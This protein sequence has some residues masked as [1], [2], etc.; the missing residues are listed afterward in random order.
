MIRW[1]AAAAVVVLGI[2]LWLTWPRALPAFTA[3]PRVAVDVG[4]PVLDTPT[5]RVDTT[6]VRPIAGKVAADP[7]AETGVIEGTI[8]DWST[9]RPVPE[10]EVTFAL[11]EA[12]SSV[13]AGGDGKF[14]FVPSRA[15]RLSL[16]TVTADGYLPFAPELE[17]SPIDVVARPGLRLTG[18]T[19]FLAP[20]LEYTGWVVD[21][22]GQFVVGAKVE[23]VD[24]ALASPLVPM[25]SQFKTD[26]AG[27]FRFHAFD[28][29]ILEARAPG[30]GPGRARLDGAAQTSH[31][32]TITLTAPGT[33][34]T[35]GRI[36]GRVVDEQGAPL[37]GAKVQAATTG[38]APIADVRSES[39]ADGRFVLEGVGKGRSRV[40]AALAG[41]A[42]LTVLAAP[43]PD[44]VVLTL[45]PAA[46][47]SGRVTAAGAPVP[48]FTLTV[49]VARGGLRVDEVTNRA[50]LDGTG[51]FVVDGLLE[52]DYLV[53]ATAHGL[54]PSK[55][56]P[57]RASTTPT[58]VTL[59]LGRGATLVGQVVDAV[60]R[61]PIPWARVTLEGARG[62]ESQQ[63][64]VVQSALTD[65]DGRF[66]LA[67]LPAGRQGVLVAAQGHH[68]RILAG[69][70]LSDGQRAGPVTAELTPLKPG[71]APQIE[72]AG[73]G[74]A[75]GVDGEALRVQNV[76][77]GG[78]AEAAGIKR[79]ELVVAVDGEAVT[80][81]GFQGAMQRIRGPEGTEV[82]LS[83][84][85]AGN[86]V[87]VP[88]LRKKIRA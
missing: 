75:L 19:I 73:A 60:D 8:V 77:P 64:P 36:V 80:S 39:G 33:S 72:L 63:L 74:L 22:D 43:G 3:P 86:V 34:F 6:P 78:G 42:T 14:H 23:V 58:P 87:V 30:F 35:D 62:G 81:L 82:R 51:E 18:L 20:A 26:D 66:E 45:P 48:S 41:R 44:E 54:A 5:P 2:V 38:N 21:P 59:S 28:G 70:E 65:S 27:E 68:L 4:E 53:V 29:A 7:E 1:A 71:E 57:A 24:A 55:E 61:K 31:R 85:R 40:T 88:V 47:L 15:G 46:K 16:Q 10:A 52:G 84:L 37:A 79:G 56:T 11:G 69:F 67:G 9:G 32:L 17:E 83:L 25:A 49:L 50:F 76:F 12:T 13:T